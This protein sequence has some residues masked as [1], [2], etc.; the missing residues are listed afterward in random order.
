MWGIRGALPLRSHTEV[1]FEPTA[2]TRA[3]LCGS[4]RSVNKRIPSHFIASAG[5]ASRLCR[6]KVA[7]QLALVAVAYL[8][9]RKGLGKARTDP[10]PPGRG[11][12][13]RQSSPPGVLE[14][15]GPR[16]LGTQ[17]CPSL[18]GLPLVSPGALSVHGRR[19][20]RPDG[21][22]FAHAVQELGA[23]GRV[24]VCLRH[25]LRAYNVRWNGHG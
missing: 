5:S 22:G 12:R 21:M 9:P 25:E 13:V 18:G 15:L 4:G 24:R 19:C 17:K 20:S 10:A 11:G 8:D 1:N 23:A 7:P 6:R 2:Y 16:W 3:R 14:R